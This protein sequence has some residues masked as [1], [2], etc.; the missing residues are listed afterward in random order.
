[1]RRGIFLILLSALIS[2][3]SIT[4]KATCN[5]EQTGITQD[6]PLEYASDLG[7]KKGQILTME[8]VGE[9]TMRVYINECGLCST[10]NDPSKRDDMARRTLDWFLKKKGYKEGTVEWY[11][12]SKVKVMS[13][14]GNLSDPEIKWGPS[15][16]LK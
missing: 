15:C 11:N 13:I 3:C 5:A 16:S 9:G 8:F 7:F 14:S 2:Y 1:M 4:E 12:R 6:L 10:F